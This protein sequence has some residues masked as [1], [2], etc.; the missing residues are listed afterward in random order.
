MPEGLDISVVVPVFN[1]A[2]TIEMLFDRVR[3]TLEGQNLSFELIFI[4]DDSAD[5]SWE[6]VEKM[7]NLHGELVR[8]FRLTRNAGQQAATF[9]GL[10]HARGSWV[11]TLDDDLQTPPEEITRL[12]A[13]AQ[14]LQADIIYG[15]YAVARQGAWRRWGARMFRLLLRR[16]APAFPDGSS[17]RLIRGSLVRK[18]P[19][20]LKQWSYVDPVLS[21][22]STRIGVVEVRHDARDKGHS[23]YSFIQLAGI[24]L[25]ILVIYSTLPLR[26]MI[27][28]GFASAM[29]SFA[30]GAYYF[31][32]KITIGAQI[33]FSALIVTITFFSGVILISLGILGLY[34]SKI[35][36]MSSGQPP[37]TVEKSI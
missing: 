37:F 33:G 28:S 13:S 21:R 1:G 10:L 32:Q 31:I 2:A 18:I 9:C 6:V 14:V 3:N 4:D 23:G 11:L 26:L 22:L 7:K 25:H 12:W 24:A 34:I 20:G 35:Y 5:D 19:P 29:A 17:F 15:K 36:E 8:G 16:V 27:A 30:L